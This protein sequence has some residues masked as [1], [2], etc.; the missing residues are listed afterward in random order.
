MNSA[1]LYLQLLRQILEE[2]RREKIANRKHVSYQLN[3]EFKFIYNISHKRCHNN[4]IEN[5]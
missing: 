1:V 3:G 4:S 5:L 2:K